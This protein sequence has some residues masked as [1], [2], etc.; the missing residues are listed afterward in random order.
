MKTVVVIVVLIGGIALIY[1]GSYTVLIYAHG[2]VSYYSTELPAVTPLIPRGYTID[3][4][5]PPNNRYLAPGTIVALYV[6]APED[7]KISLSIEVLLKG[8]GTAYRIDYGVNSSFRIEL[9]YPFEWRMK[10][11]IGILDNSSTYTVSL[12][13]AETKPVAVRLFGIDP[14]KGFTL[15]AIGFLI[16]ALIFRNPSAMRTVREYCVYASLPTIVLLDFIS[17]LLAGEEFE[18]LA[19]PRMLYSTV[20]LPQFFVV[21]L[22]L[23]IAFSLILLHAVKSRKYH[24]IGKILLALAYSALTGLKSIGPIIN[25]LASLSSIIPLLGWD[26]VYTIT[27]AVSYLISAAVS[28]GVYRKIITIGRHIE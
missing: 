15:A 17:T 1:A 21:N 6:N 7:K 10:I 4:Y 20:G 28:L 27:L 26:H 14:F 9:D 2:G 25:Y 12:E 11:L 3:Y 5:Y 18:M 13:I 22:L 16:L 19:I 8:D 23:S 24:T